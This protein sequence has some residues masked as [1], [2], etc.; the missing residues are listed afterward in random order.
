LRACSYDV[1]LKQ[2]EITVPPE[3]IAQPILP[4]CKNIYEE[5]TALSLKCF[6]PRGENSNNNKLQ[7]ADIRI[8]A[9]NFRAVTLKFRTAAMFVTA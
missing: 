5:L 8:Y 4:I 2:N 1:L 3:F 7:F 9:F 6:R